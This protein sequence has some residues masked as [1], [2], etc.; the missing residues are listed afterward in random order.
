MCE[1]FS[2]QE[3]CKV[4]NYLYYSPLK[5]KQQCCERDTNEDVLLAPTRRIPVQD[6][7]EGGPPHTRYVTDNNDGQRETNT[8]RQSQASRP[9]SGESSYT[10]L[11]LPRLHDH[12]SLAVKVVFKDAH[13]HGLALKH[14]LDTCSPSRGPTG[15]KPAT[16]QVTVTL[17]LVLLA[18][19]GV[20]GT[21][22]TRS[23]HHIVPAG[24]GVPGKAAGN[25]SLTVRLIQSPGI[26]QL[27][28]RNDRAI[29]YPSLPDTYIPLTSL[30]VRCSD[31]PKSAVY[32]GMQHVYGSND[33]PVL[34]Y[35]VYTREFRLI[36][37][38]SIP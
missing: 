27:V 16:K 3:V 28:N 2:T 33:L 1:L 36:W 35:P 26:L 14:L 13:I 9:M 10:L 19:I 17:R 12:Q 11:V 18:T 38:P 21:I 34:K 32:I 23:F 30:S 8:R 22:K 5:S 20:G 31:L 24:V 7:T 6:R 25:T 37:S 15:R 4:H 29:L